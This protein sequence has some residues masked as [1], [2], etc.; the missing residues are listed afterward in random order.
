MCDE[1]QIIYDNRHA[2]DQWILYIKKEI[3]APQCYV[4][5]GVRKIQ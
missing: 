4:F 1:K 2:N 3:P 5:G